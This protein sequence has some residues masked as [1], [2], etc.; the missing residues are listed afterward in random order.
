MFGAPTS[1]D[2]SIIGDRKELDILGSHLSPYCFPYV[3]ENIANGTLK[4]NGVI[5][6]TFKLEEWEKAFDHATGKYGD[7]KVAFIP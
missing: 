6:N 3:I 1:V 2:W 4:T 5:L 7:L